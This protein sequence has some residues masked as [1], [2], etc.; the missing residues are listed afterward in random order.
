[1][2]WTTFDL[3]WGSIDFMLIHSFHT[4]KWMNSVYW[5]FPAVNFF[6]FNYSSQNWD[7]FVVTPCHFR[8]SFPCNLIL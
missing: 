7:C 4:C 2:L 3:I 8:P 6:F 5:V 1:L